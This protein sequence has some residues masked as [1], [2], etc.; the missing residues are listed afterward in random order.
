MEVWD[1]IYIFT[2][3][4]FNLFDFVSMLIAS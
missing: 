3:T 1:Y 4:Q 2:A